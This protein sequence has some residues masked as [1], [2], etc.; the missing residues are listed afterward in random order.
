MKGSN[1]SSLAAPGWDERALQGNVARGDSTLVTFTSGQLCV[2]SDVG[3][4]EQQMYLQLRWVG[5]CSV[6]LVF[7]HS[8]PTWTP[9]PASENQERLSLPEGSLCSACTAGCGDLAN[10]VSKKGNK[11]WVCSSHGVASRT[12]RVTTPVLALLRH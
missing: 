6:P 11:S 12:S 9:E 7:L 5:H 2:C 3:S 10:S 4:T 8:A 1:K